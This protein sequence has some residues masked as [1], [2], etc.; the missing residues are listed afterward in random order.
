MRKLCAVRLALLVLCIVSGCVSG[1]GDGR[2]DSG[3]ASYVGSEGKGSMVVTS[4]FEKSG[5]VFKEGAMPEV[6]LRD[7]MR[8]KVGTVRGFGRLRFTGLSAGD[9]VIEPA[10]RPCNANCGNL[11][12]RTGS[13]S[14]E[15]EVGSRSTRVRVVYRIGESCKVYVQ[16]S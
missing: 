9:Y 3:D 7:A 6:V 2:S 15:V 16:P 12:E 8:H 14:A 4:R 11:E 5:S 10:L 13:C 1:G